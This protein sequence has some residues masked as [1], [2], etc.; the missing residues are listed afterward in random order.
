MTQ[1][2]IL[3]TGVGGQ[4]VQ[5]ISKA[6]ATAAVND[7]KYVQ[8]LPSYG[9]SM[10]GGK[11]NADLTVGDGSLR[12]VPL[13]HH[14]WSAICTDQAYW[15]TISGKLAPDAVVVVDSTVFKVEV[16]HTT[17][18]VPAVDIAVELGSRMSAGFVLIG[19][20]AALTGLVGIE[21]LVGAMMQL[22]PPYRTQHIES[23][24]RAIHAGAA[25][26]PALAAPAWPTVGATP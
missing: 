10:R 19:A 20:Y 2:S 24:E 14:A 21:S 1:R 15:E 17:F 5:I 7:G 18:R 8:L 26:V 22:V 11:T 9:G 3:F 4:G 13:V 23:N 25:A 6:L 12:A 16:P